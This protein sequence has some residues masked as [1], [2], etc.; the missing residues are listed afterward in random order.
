VFD[1]ALAHWAEHGLGWRAALDRSSG[2]W[3]GFV[4]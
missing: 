4:D 2:E 1:R 3:L